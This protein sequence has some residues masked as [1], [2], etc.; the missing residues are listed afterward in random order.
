[1]SGLEVVRALGGWRAYCKAVKGRDYYRQRFVESVNDAWVVVGCLVA[2][3][4]LVV[5]AVIV[6][7]IH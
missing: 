2:G 1:M 3:G 7:V 5:G 4:I 6:T